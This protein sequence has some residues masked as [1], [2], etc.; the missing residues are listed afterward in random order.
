VQASR[1]LFDAAAARSPT[2][3]RELLYHDADCR[4]HL[5]LRRAN[6]EDS[7]EIYVY[8]DDPAATRAAFMAAVEKAP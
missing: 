8:S 4:A 3:F 5:R 7:L 2:L 6:Y 1:S